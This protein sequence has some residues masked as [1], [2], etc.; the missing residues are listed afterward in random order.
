MRNNH[1]VCLIQE[2]LGNVIRDIQDLLQYRASV[3][4]T[5]LIFFFVVCLASGCK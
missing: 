4:E 3:L 2:V 1:A 5:I